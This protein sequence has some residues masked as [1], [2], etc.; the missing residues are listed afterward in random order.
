[1][2][3]IK[4]RFPVLLAEH[5][6]KISDV[7]RATGISR[8]TLTNLYYGRGESLSY[9]VLERLCTHFGCTASELLETSTE[10]GDCA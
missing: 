2:T 6:E 10:G 5:R 8:T 4:N 1:M 9:K 3:R 7:S